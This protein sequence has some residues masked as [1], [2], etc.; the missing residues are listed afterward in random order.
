[1]RIIISPAKNMSQNNKELEYN[2]LP[3]FL[4]DTKKILS[5]LREKN[6]TELQNI[7]KCN[8]KLLEENIQ[9]IKNMDLTKN[10]TPAVLTY[11]GMVFKHLI[12]AVLEDKNIEY[13]QKNLRILSGFYGVLKPLDGITP[14]RLEMQSK[15]KIDSFKN[16]YD[17]WGDKIYREILDESKIII[18]LASKE[19][20][21]AIE[22]FLTE[23]IRF[24]TC[25]FV[26]KS[27]DQLVTKGTYSKMARGEMARFIAKHNLEKPEELKK[28][29]KL[30]YI[31]R[32]DLSSETEYIFERIY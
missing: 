20:T 24:I 22:K 15:L 6:Q 32:E 30:G 10:L 26:E 13:L 7:W 17:F 21:K 16:L 1:M 12:P 28:F 31:F 3:I 23:D 11:E 9:R 5:T 29:N 8:D 14:Y 19:Y 18:N 4:E 2:S 25:S 27:G